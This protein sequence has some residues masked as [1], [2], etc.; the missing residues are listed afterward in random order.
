MKK[1]EWRL[2]RVLEIRIMQEQKARVELFALTE[3]LAATRGELLIQKKIL[4]NIIK[5]IA[6]KSARERLAEQELFL[7]NSVSSNERIK[8]LVKNIKELELQQKQKLDEVV[9]L[10]QAKE[11]MEKL[12][13]Q[14]K[15]VY[16]KEQ[17]KFEQKEIDEESNIL[18][19]RNHN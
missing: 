17:E 3:K 1:F 12:Q 11:G 4:E 13:A 9:K 15:E 2:Q 18:F 10:R 5:N 19:V 6:G 14:A 7:K 16:I 8:K